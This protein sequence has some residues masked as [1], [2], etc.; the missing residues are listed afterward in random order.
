V[1]A[2]AGGSG[3]ALI[4]DVDAD[5]LPEGFTMSENHRDDSWVNG[6]L[7]IENTSKFT[8]EELAPYAGRYVA[9]NLEGTQI[10]VSGADEEELYRNIAVAGLQLSKVVQTYIPGPDEE[11]MF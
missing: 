8:Y 11:T 7:F 4:G 5:L 3:T 6:A 10:L 2:A 9:W 1:A